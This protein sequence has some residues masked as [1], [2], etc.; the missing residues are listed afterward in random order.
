MKNSIKC[1]SAKH[2][3]AW[4]LVGLLTATTLTPVMADTPQAPIRYEVVID[5]S[6]SMD[7]PFAAPVQPE[8]ADG[9][10]KLLG[11]KRRL[12]R[13]AAELPLGTQVTVTTFD[14]RI[15]HVADITLHTEADRQLLDAALQSVKTD[16]GGTF[17]WRAL[18][19]RLTAAKEFADANPEHAVRVLLYTDGQNHD[20]ASGLTHKSLLERFAG[21]LKESLQLDWITIGYDMNAQEKADWEQAGAHIRKAVRTED[22]NPFRADFRL[23]AA[24]LRVGEELALTDNSLGNVSRR[25]VTWGDGSPTETG[26]LFRHTYQ[27]PGDYTVRYRVESTNGKI[28]ESSRQVSVTAP[29]PL[30]AKVVMDRTTVIAGETVTLRD[31]TDGDVKDRRWL[32]GAGRIESTSTVKLAFDRAGKHEIK[33]VVRDAFGQQSDASTTVNVQL[34]VAPR[35]AFRLSTKSAEPGDVITAI[36]ESV[37]D[38]VWQEWVL[39]DGST[40]QEQHVTFEV[41][42]YGDQQI[43][44]TVRDRFDQT[45]TEVTAFSVPLPLAPVADL[46]VPES[47]RPGEKWAAVD[48][49]T[50]V[51]ERA[52]LRINGELVQYDKVVDRLAEN[53]GSEVYIALKVENVAGVSEVKRRVKVLQ[54]DPPEPGFTLGTDEPMLGDTMKITSTATGKIDSVAYQVSGMKLPVVLENAGRGDKS[55]DF[56]CDRLGKIEII[57]TVKGPGGEFS[58]ARTFTVMSRAVQPR[59]RFVVTRDSSREP[60]TITFDNQSTGTIERCEF[61]PCDGSDVVVKAGTDGFSHEYAA[62]EFTPIVKVFGPEE[63]GQP[64]IVWHS[65]PIV[66]KAPLPAWVHQLWWMVP[67]TIAGFGVCGFAASQ[68]RRR[69]MQAARTKLSGVLTVRKQDV[70]RYRENVIFEGTASSETAAINDDD[71]IVVTAALDHA[72]NAV[73]YRAELIREGREPVGVDLDLDTDTNLDRYTIRYQA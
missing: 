42:E 45:S 53:P 50:G 57:Q 56:T 20:P 47:V 37:G 61:D 68:H 6:D 32:L 28:D 12:A 44:L 17:L 51:I 35:S 40:S 7:L 41:A 49:S 71:S 25:S 46:S 34:P 26:S 19:E 18:R 15:R 31:A 60:A 30:V 4:L 59:P 69:L 63:L 5:V 54:Y 16:Q 3:F 72:T 58:Q 27:Q 11:V 52:E 70:P 23:N 24:A 64:P 9:K 43:T 67:L 8:L 29:L 55:F 48:R 66:V 10:S 65:D 21:D 33:L 38:V 62:G 22:L 39:P 13:L 14:D 2:F 36:N 73:R 1:F